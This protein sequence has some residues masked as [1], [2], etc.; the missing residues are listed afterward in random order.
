MESLCYSANKESED[1]N[2]VSTS[3]TSQMTAAKVM[4]VIARLLDCAGQAADA[5]SAHTRVEK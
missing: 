4:D 5:V 3:L 2:D 1:A